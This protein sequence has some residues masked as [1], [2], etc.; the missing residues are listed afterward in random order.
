MR[1]LALS[2]VGQL[3]RIFLQVEE[4]FVRWILR[5]VDKVA[6]VGR[7]TTPHAFPAGNG[8]GHGEEFAEK[9]FAPVGDFVAAKQRS[10]AAASV[11]FGRGE[12]G[13]VDHGRGEVISERTRPRLAFGS[14]G[15]WTIKG[16]RKD[17]S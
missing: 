16:T 13:Q 7:A 15:S 10:Q 6:S 8:L 4:K 14:R 2:Q 12:S 1:F 11:G 9:V 3:I 5:T 17:C